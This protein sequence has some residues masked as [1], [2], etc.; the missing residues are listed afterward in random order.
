MHHSPT[1][2]I[3]TP[4]Y[5]AECYIAEAI[6]SVLAQTY[7]DWELLVVDD[8]SADETA[9]IVKSFSDTRITLIQ[10]ENHGVSSA[11]NKGLELAKGQYITFL[12]ADDVLPLD[13]LRSRI[14]HLDNNPDVDIVDGRIIIKDREM[15]EVSREYQPYYNGLLLPRLTA[16]DDKVFFNVCY[17]FRR[18][19]LGD[20]RFNTR[21]THAED[22]LFYLEL[23]AK[24]R[25]VYDFVQD[26]V[27]V[28]TSG[29]TSAMSNLQGLQE[30][31]LQLIAE[32]KKLQ[33][34][35][36]VNFFMLKAKIA[37]I[38]FL[39]WL[40]Q[41]QLGNAMRSVYLVFQCI[42]KDGR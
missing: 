35:S 10:Q 19:I 12:D 22:L 29:H 5:N 26:E 38:M 2:S 8:G 36:R 39:S 31:Y 28:Y 14:D 23:A 32:V 24:N 25:A 34:A 27:Y 20:V 17:L 6:E 30:G 41:K 16:L 15:K 33:G 7:I 1:V 40:G 42:K 13:S 21:M 3:I 4:A 9:K 37:K 11:R 18:N